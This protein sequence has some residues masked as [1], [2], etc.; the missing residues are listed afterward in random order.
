MT[1]IAIVQVSAGFILAADGRLAPVDDAAPPDEEMLALIDDHQQKIF[2]ISDSQKNMAYAVIGCAIDPSGFNLPK[3]IEAQVGRIRHRLFG[4][5]RQYLLTLG[6]KIKSEINRAKQEGKIQAFP[7]LDRLEQSNAWKFA[8]MEIAGYFDGRPVLCRVAFFHYSGDSIEFTLIPNQ[9]GAVLSG[10]EIVSRE[11]YHWNGD[12]I[13][14]SRFF[15]YATLLDRESSLDNAEQYAAG[16]VRAC[17]SPL[18]LELDPRCKA[19]G[20][21]VHVAEITP[22]G[23]KWRIPP[24]T[25]E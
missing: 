14:G 12:P 11:M 8:R 3:I 23:F 20:G 22:S 4:D 24:A 25:R 17:C 7:L 6:D 9:R 15:E 5:C 10:S 13:A 18:A 16:Y 2:E 21:H 19:M 1:A